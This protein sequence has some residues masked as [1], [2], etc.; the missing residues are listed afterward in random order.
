MDLGKLNMFCVALGTEVVG[1]PFT[2]Q[3]K[4]EWKNCG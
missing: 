2:C 4:L 1:V 3:F